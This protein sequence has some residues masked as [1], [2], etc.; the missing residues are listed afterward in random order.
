MSLI[1][2]FRFTLLFLTPLTLK[3]FVSLQFY[4]TE[5]AK[6][7]IDNDQYIHFFLKYKRFQKTYYNSESAENK[8]ES[9]AEMLSVILTV[10]YLEIYKCQNNNINIFLT[11]L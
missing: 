5:I 9:G 11:Q 1:K 4:G 10:N 3:V 2:L 8:E 6:V 7:P